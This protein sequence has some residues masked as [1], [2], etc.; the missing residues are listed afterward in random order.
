MTRA[1]LLD[2]LRRQAVGDRQAL[3]V[4]GQHLVAQARGARLGRHAL[5]RV[6]TVRPIGMGVAVALQIRPRD[7]PGQRAGQG[8][9]DLAAILAQLGLDE[10]QAQ[11][12]VDLGLG[13]EGRRACVLV[14][15]R[16]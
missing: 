10:G 15:E 4:V 2:A 1:F 11:E 6:V 16:W 12:V 3:G 13:R 8:R 5:D 9:L 7:E 14:I